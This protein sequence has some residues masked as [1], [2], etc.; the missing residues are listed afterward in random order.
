MSSSYKTAGPVT[1]S[2]E[3]I[4]ALHQKLREMRHDVN[5]QLTNI[6]AAAELIRLRPEGA[7]DRLKVLLEQPHKIARL[8]DGFSKEFEK[9]LRLDRA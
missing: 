9:Q 4:V 1:L 3:E 5:G 2:G 8:L 6:V 7:E